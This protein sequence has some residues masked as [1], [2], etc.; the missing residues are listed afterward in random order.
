[1]DSFREYSVRQI[2]YAAYLYS[3]HSTWLNAKALFPD[4]RNDKPIA[5]SD[6]LFIFLF[7]LLVSIGD[8]IDA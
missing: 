3:A 8:T 1:M 6:R 4:S 2:F 5:N 7:L